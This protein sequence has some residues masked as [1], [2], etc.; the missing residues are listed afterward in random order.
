MLSRIVRFIILQL[1][2]LFYPRIEARGE[3]RLPDRPTL[4]VLNHPNGLLDAAGADAG[5]GPACLVSEPRAPS[6]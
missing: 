4:F 1:I 2:H 3:E 5:A 6:L